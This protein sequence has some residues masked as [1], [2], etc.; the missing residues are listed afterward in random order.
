MEIKYP[1]ATA[2]WDKAEFDAM[3]RVIKSNSFTMGKEVS[4]FE[5]DFAN[6][7][8][9]KYA[10]M[11]NSGSS[12]NLLMIASL[13]FKKDNPLK[14]G[15]EIIVPAVSWSTTYMPLQQYQ[16]KV[17]F[18]DID[19]HTLNFDLNKL[20]EAV[21]SKT[22]A[23]LGVN[24]LGNPND[25]NFIKSLIKDK[26]IYLLEDNCESMGARYEGEYAGSIGLM[27]TFSTF[28]SH[29]ISTME[30]GVLVTYDKELYHI[31]L[32]LRAHGWTRN[33]PKVNHITGIKSDNSF[34]ES[35]KFV[36]PGYNLRPLELSGA[37]GQKQLKKL[38]LIIENRRENAKIF[39]NIISKYEWLIPQYEIGESSWFGFSLIIKPTSGKEREKLVEIFESFGIEYRPI[40]AGNF[41]KNDVI[42]FFN[43]EVSS[44]LTNANLVDSHGLFIGNHH[45]NLSKEF[46]VLEQALEAYN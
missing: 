19:L 33:L 23:I 1:L 25:Y 13:F 42:S 14:A 9:K 43:Y 6:F 15:D 11:L 38:P 3:N 31:S 29:H 40:V 44:E 5:I 22:K 8:N 10:I 32:S 45:Y 4:K 20:S 41:V 36:L 24:L 16:L 30:G 35:F 27:G 17:K 37:I 12:A 18:V 28:F 2:T 7:F 26:N 21:S 39:T 46:K 34:E